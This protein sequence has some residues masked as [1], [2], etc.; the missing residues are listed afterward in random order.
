MEP[1]PIPTLTASAPASTDQHEAQLPV[2]MLP[3]T[4][5]MREVLFDPAHAVNHA[6][7]CG[8]CA[9]STMMASTPALG[10]ASRAL[11]YPRPA[12]R[13]RA[14]ASLPTG[15]TSGIGKLVCLVMS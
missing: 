15:I 1:G 7:Y 9:V 6:T 2:A 11:R 14:R 4:T 3:P 10:Y 5:S 8:P 13:Q 12:H